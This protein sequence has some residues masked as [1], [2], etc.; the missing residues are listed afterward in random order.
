MVPGWTPKTSPCSSGWRARE[1]AVNRPNQHLASGTVVVEYERV[2]D[3]STPAAPP[4]RI[5]VLPA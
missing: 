3:P 5:V 4:A 1:S 2:T